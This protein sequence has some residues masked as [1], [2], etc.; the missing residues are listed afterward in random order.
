MHK[1][2]I[3]RHFVEVFREFSASLELTTHVH[4]ARAI[5]CCIISKQTE[6]VLLL[7]YKSMQQKHW[8]ANNGSQSIKKFNISYG[9]QKV[10]TLSNPPN[11]WTAPRV[12][13]IVHT[14]TSYSL[15]VIWKLFPYDFKVPFVQVMW[16]KF[17][18]HFSCHACRT[19]RPSHSP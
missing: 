9:T 13:N 12:I 3:L 1:Q 14:I 10:N 16:L 18:K 19:S 8:E 15:K 6:T 4:S 7:R 11:S 2:K 5:H 17:C